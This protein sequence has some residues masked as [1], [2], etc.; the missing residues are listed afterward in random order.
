MIKSLLDL[1]EFYSKHELAKILKEP[2][3]ATVREGIYYCSNSK[4]TIFF[5]DLEKEGKEDR[6]HFNDF[7]D[8]DIFHWDSQTTQHITPLKF[9]KL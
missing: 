1:G 2:N 8:G 4:S 3:L 6:F 5:V 9:K 7:F